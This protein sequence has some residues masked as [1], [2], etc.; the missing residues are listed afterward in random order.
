MSVQKYDNGFIPESQFTVTLTGK[1]LPVSVPCWDSSAHQAQPRSPTNSHSIRAGFF[2]LAATA[3]KH[4]RSLLD[5]L[6]GDT[7][8]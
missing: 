1:A 6:G 3:Q 7:Q 2:A 4:R 5:G 8:K